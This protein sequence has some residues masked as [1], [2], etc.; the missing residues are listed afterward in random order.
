MT[1][2]IVLKAAELPAT[3]LAKME[4]L[5]TVLHL[6]KDKTA[7]L[8]FLQ[9]YG[10]VVK[11]MAL[12][13]TIVDR[14]LLEALPALEVIASYSAGLDNVDV[15]AV[16]ARGIA[17]HNSSHI[18]SRDVANTAVG[19]LLAVTR[20]I[21]NADAFVR[22]GR[23]NGDNSYPLGRSIVGMPVGIVGLGAIGFELA[24]RLKAFGAQVAYSGP[25]PKPV[26]LPYYP[27]TLAL[28]EACDALVLTCPLTDQT[29]HLVDAAVLDALGPRG[30][31]IN[32]SRGSVI[33]EV[34][35]VAALAQG[36]IG[37]AGLDVFEFEPHVPQELL[38]DPRLVLTPHIGSGTKETRQAM[39]DNVVNSLAGH[40][41]MDTC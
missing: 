34:A 40:F 2:P 17:L 5:F 23:W 37:G 29:H 18:L 21:V 31:L 35:L 7:I 16:R 25:N 26:D 38:K 30:Y 15:E 22:D 12:R 33:D 13:K 1:K 19:L 24:K 3:T 8:E 20:D 41:G 11:G 27:T 28:A 36:R 6:P 4:T 39:A 9:E 32:I 10:A 14:D